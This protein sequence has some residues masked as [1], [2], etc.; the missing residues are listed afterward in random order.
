MKDPH[1]PKTP[2]LLEVSGATPKRRGRRKTDNPL[3]LKERQAR[4]AAKLKEQNLERRT[5]WLSKEDIDI[6]ASIKL[7][8]G[9]RNN[10]EALRFILKRIREELASS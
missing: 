1:D 3:P 7:S 10:D 8:N 6:I 5:F 4:F 2:D 9:M